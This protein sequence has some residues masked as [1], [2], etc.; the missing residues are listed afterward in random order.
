MWGLPHIDLV[1]CEQRLALTPATTIARPNRCEVCP[2]AIAWNTELPNDD[3]LRK[4][5]GFCLVFWSLPKTMRIPKRRN[6][7]VV[8]L[9]SCEIKMPLTACPLILAIS[10]S[11][12]KTLSTVSGGGVNII[13]WLLLE[14]SATMP[15]SPVDCASALIC[16]S[17][18]PVVCPITFIRVVSA[19]PS[20]MPSYAGASWFSDR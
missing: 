4:S 5:I 16:A 11:L 14:R 8:R 10:L 13:R 6:K 20:S 9:N 3:M 1:A 2:A 15:K 19:M 17:V 12:V 7:Y 18:R